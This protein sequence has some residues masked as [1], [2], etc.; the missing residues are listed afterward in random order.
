MFLPIETIQ[1]R[2]LLSFGPET[3]PFELR[4]LNVLIG[5]NGSG[6]SNFIEAI[7][8]LHALPRDMREHFRNRGGAQDWAWKGV[9]EKRPFSIDVRGH[10]RERKTY[11]HRITIDT[12]ETTPEVVDE[13]V[14]FPWRIGQGPSIPIFGYEKRTPVLYL[15]GVPQRLD[16][17]VFDRTQSV[18]SNNRGDDYGVGLFIVTMPLFNLLERMKFYRARDFDLTGAFRP[19]QPSNLSGQS[20]EK[21]GR[22]LA[23]VLTRVRSDLEIRAEFNKTMSE[24]YEDFYELEIETYGGMSRVVFL[25]RNLKASVPAAR[26]SDGTLRWLALVAILLD[27]APPPLIC[28]EEP[29]TGHHP[30]V[31]V[32]LAKLL[33]KASERTQLIVTTHSD[34]L[35]DAL[36]D[37]PED[38]VVCEKVDGSTTMKRLDAGHLKKWLE[39]YS[40]GSLW[41]RGTLGG[42]RF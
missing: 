12:A 14:H 15:K 42:N 6:K 26:L 19:W 32:G 25:E 37:S 5:A 20:L 38:V 29:E 22:N 21:S 1:L 39:N 41:T 10:L 17:K 36:T 11:S 9:K 34:I 3:E 23:A 8:L 28:L 30:D 35:I 4:A 16:T 7:E 33:K 13:S 31:I 18:L 40:L 2:N 24:F 27:P